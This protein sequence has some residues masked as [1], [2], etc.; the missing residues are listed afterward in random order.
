[1]EKEIMKS[2]PAE[3]ITSDIQSFHC[4]TNRSKQ[5]YAASD[6]RKTKKYINF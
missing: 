2:L 1:M 4:G 3:V 5:Y 6:L